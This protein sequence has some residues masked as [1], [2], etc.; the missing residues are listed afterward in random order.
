MQEIVP[1]SG[2]TYRE[3]NRVLHQT[4][5]DKQVENALRDTGYDL[6]AAGLRR[7]FLP[8]IQL[9][10]PI[11]ID[12]RAKGKDLWDMLPVVQ[13]Q[14][15]WARRL[16]ES[17][18]VPPFFDY[19]QYTPLVVELVRFRKAV[20]DCPQEDSLSGPNYESWI[21][22]DAEVYNVLAGGIH[23]DDEDTGTIQ[24]DERDDLIQPMTKMAIETLEERL[25]AMELD[26]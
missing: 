6:S 15:D 7:A 5:R 10:T 24:H 16:G 8:M 23:E 22:A 25:V 14:L 3:K 9:A 18:P 1:K 19:D 13:Q 12:A 2:M 20:G 4:R 17:K 26:N 21:M 11:F